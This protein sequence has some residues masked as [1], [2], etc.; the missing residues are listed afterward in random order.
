MIYIQSLA[1][2]IIW[3]H[4][5]RAGPCMFSIP[6]FQFPHGSPSQQAN[7]QSIWIAL[8]IYNFYYF[9]KSILK[10]KKKWLFSFSCVISFYSRN[11]NCSITYLTFFFFFF[12]LGIFGWARCL[13][14]SDKQT[15]QLDIFK[16]EKFLVFSVKPVARGF[17]SVEE[18]VPNHVLPP[19]KTNFTWWRLALPPPSHNFQIDNLCISFDSSFFHSHSVLRP[20]GGGQLKHSKEACPP[21]HPSPM[22]TRTPSPSP[23]SLPTDPSPTPP[24]RSP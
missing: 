16:R 13:P 17:W 24:P 15:R 22:R 1:K 19:A 23:C 5:L 9:Y 8:S 20:D 21:P 18:L 4:I 12:V 14:T 6:S 11:G 3:Q 2:H 7:W 10:K